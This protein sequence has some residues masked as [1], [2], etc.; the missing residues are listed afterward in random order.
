MGRGDK[1]AATAAAKEQQ[2]VGKAGLAGAGAG[3]ESAI[4]DYRSE[5]TK[6]KAFDPYG[7]EYEGAQ[8]YSSAIEHSKGNRDVEEALD[9]FGRRTGGLNAAGGTAELSDLR[10]K[11]ARDRAEAEAQRIEGTAD[12]KLGKRAM[13]LEAT[14]VM[15]PWYLAQLG[16]YVNLYGGGVNTQAQLASQPGMLGGLLG[17]GIGAGGSALA[18][19]MPAIIA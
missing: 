16:P 7:P 11:L 3:A 1:K 5:L 17:A 6:F 12:K 19:A 9:L 18:A 8:R 14:G 13:D 2:A 10:R 15:P 4:G